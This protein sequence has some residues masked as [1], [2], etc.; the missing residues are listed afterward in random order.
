M[1]IVL[2][3]CVVDLVL[4]YLSTCVVDIVLEYLSSC[5][6]DLVLEYLSVKPRTMNLIFADS[7]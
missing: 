3:S 5:V 4:E 1:V 7:T 2:L 6:V